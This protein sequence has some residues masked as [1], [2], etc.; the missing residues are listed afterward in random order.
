MAF[1]AIPGFSFTVYVVDGIVTRAI[2]IDERDFVA[3]YSR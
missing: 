1:N 2:A 3:V